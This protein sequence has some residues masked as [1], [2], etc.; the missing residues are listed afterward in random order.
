[1]EDEK[2]P[3]D[4]QSANKPE[5]NLL[6]SEGPFGNK[7]QDKFESHHNHNRGRRESDRLTKHD[8]LD[9][10][11][12]DAVAQTLEQFFKR[13]R[14][15]QFFKTLSFVLM[16][17]LGVGGFYL[18]WDSNR[19]ENYAAEI[20]E[21]NQRQAADLEQKIKTKL[22]WMRQINKT[23]LDMRQVRQFIIFRCIFNYHPLN[24][25]E[26]QVLRYEAQTTVIKA[27]TG[28]RFIFNDAVEN[29]T[30]E[31]IHFDETIKDVCAKNA[32]SDEIW[33][34]YQ[35]SLDDLMG[36]SIKDDEDKLK[37]LR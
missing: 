36:Q 32:P 16:A 35:R 17:A 20:R 9:I 28:S 21:Q 24:Q 18:A 26:Q 25:Y 30:R 23:I 37:K 4:G 33:H 10:L 34:Q 19:Q 31:L 3:L 6:K 11:K 1:M 13:N 29:K 22:E 12:H 27:Y 2:K 14:W 8:I 15:A 7:P 5:N